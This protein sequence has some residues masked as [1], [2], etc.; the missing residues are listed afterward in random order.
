RLL[1]ASSG[2]RFSSACLARPGLAGK[3]PASR[4][5]L[6]A[7]TATGWRSR[8]LNF[9]DNG[10]RHRARNMVTFSRVAFSLAATGFL[11]SQ[12]VAANAPGALPESKGPVATDTM[13]LAAYRAVYDL[14]LAKA[15]GSKSPTSARGRIAFDFTGSACDGYVQNFRQ[16]T[17]LQ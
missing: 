14:T 3:M 12:A 1:L 9:V 13:P 5:T 11:I 16:L 2:K 10:R 8:D 17:E 7:F 15:V 6:I 4:A